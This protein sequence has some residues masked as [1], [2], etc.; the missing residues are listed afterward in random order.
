MPYGA[1]EDGSVAIGS[2]D[3]LSSEVQPTLIGQAAATTAG[4]RALRTFRIW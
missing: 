3:L 1:Q 4:G 2:L